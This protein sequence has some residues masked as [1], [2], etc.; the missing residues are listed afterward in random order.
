MGRRQS[1]L[2]LKTQSWSTLPRLL[3]TGLASSLSETGDSGSASCARCRLLGPPWPHSCGTPQVRLSLV[4]NS[5]YAKQNYV[6]SCRSGSHPIRSQGTN[7]K[8]DWLLMLFN[9]TCISVFTEWTRSR[10]VMQDLLISDGCA[11]LLRNHT[12]R[13]AQ[14]SERARQPLVIICILVRAQRDTVVQDSCQEDPIKV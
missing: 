7:S 14:L 3:N 11:R 6:A 12:L 9:P 4:L 5:W 10:R 13:Y 8:S 2:E 1:R